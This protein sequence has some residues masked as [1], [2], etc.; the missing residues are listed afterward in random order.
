MKVSL[1]ASL[2]PLVSAFQIP[3]FPTAQDALSAADG[4]IHNN[5]H[6]NPVTVLSP[7]NDI[8]LS[9]IDGDDHVTITSAMHPVSDSSPT[10]ADYCVDCHGRNT[11]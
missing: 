5:A 6:E 3:K 1:V 11:K 4:L 10:R 9:S 2:V 7:G 8:S